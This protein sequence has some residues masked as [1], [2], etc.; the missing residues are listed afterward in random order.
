MWQ[1]EVFRKHNWVFYFPRNLQFWIVKFLER[2]LECSYKNSFDNDSILVNKFFIE[3]SVHFEIKEME[4]PYFAFV[5]FDIKILKE[6][7]Y[8]IHL[9]ILKPLKS[10]KHV[11]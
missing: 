6:L 4:S 5:V 8:R 2:R 10:F 1:F 3:C 7:I 11:T 9:H